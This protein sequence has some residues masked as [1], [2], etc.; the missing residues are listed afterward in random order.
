MGKLDNSIINRL[1]FNIRKPARYIGHE[2][3]LV[4]K[5]NSF[6]KMAICYPDLYE[7]GMSNNGIK[8]IY[9]IANRAGDVSC[10]RVFAVGDDFEQKIRS[11]GIP[12]YTL[13]SYTPLCELDIVG[14]NIAYE[15]LYTNILQMLD[16]GQIPLLRKYRQEG[17]PIIIGGGEAVS[18]PMPLVDFF[19]AF[20]IGDGEE[21]ISDILNTVRSAKTGSLKRNETV[22]LLGEIEGVYIPDISNSHEYAGKK[23]SSARKQVRKRISKNVNLSNPVSPII[24]SMSIVQE[25]LVIEVTR[26]CK[27]LCNYCHSGFYELP[28]RYGDPEVL[29]NRFF[30]LLKN[31]HYSELTLSSLSISDYNYLIRLLNYIMP[32]LIERGISISLP[33]LKVNKRTLPVIQEISDIRKSSLTFA[34]E[35]GCEEIRNKANKK[36]NTDDIIDI[37]K[38]IFNNGWNT[39]KLYFMIGLP[40]FEEYDEADAIISLLKQIYIA[41]NKKKHLNVTISPFVPKPH[42]PFQWEKQAGSDYLLQT[43]LKIKKSLPRSISIKEHNVHASM[44]EG[45]MARGDSKLGKVIYESYMSGCRLDSWKEFFKFDIWQKNLNKLEGWQNYFDKKNESERLPWDFIS[46]GFESIITRQKNKIDKIPDKTEKPYH[47]ELDTNAIKEAV[48]R[49]EKKYNTAARIRIKFSKT[50]SAKYISHLDLISVIVRGLRLINLPVSFTQGFN[51][52]EKISMGYPLPVGIE[53]VCELCDIELHEN[54]SVADIPK[55]LSAKLPDGIDA[56]YAGYIDGKESIMSIT[57]ASEFYVEI[58]DPGMRNNFI[59]NLEL[60]KDL[61]KNTKKGVKIVSFDKAVISYNIKQDIVSQNTEGIVIITSTGNEDSVR[62]DD[63]VLSLADTVYD[64]FYNFR[65]IKLKQYKKKNNI[66]EIIE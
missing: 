17:D 57:S 2:L 35:S 23:K 27:N 52:R 33:S 58:K 10:E 34:V 51:K 24:P 19:D 12:L 11:M 28:Y 25:R 22:K 47:D 38:H 42:T 63:L 8:I 56:I 21:G 1:V 14:F 66:L 18:N 29:R 50:D 62:I 20:F 48:S 4:K 61:T 64:E 55:N 15:L 45:I 39:L 44:L 32:E 3:N 49:F 5:D 53:S 43:V 40:G 60:K 7:I 37:A 41:G 54:V 65:I 31:A 16:L 9:D 6:I 13:E 36:L 30:D 26:G 46:T 59:K